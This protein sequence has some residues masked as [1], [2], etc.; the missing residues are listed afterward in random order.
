MKKL[1]ILLLCLS[2][3]SV[4]F[5]QNYLDLFKLNYGN[6]GKMDETQSDNTSPNWIESATAS[7]TLPIPL[8]EKVAI[9]SGADTEWFD[10]DIVPAT[11]TF[12]VYSLTLK[13][14]LSV[15]HTDRLSATYIVLPKIAADLQ[16]RSSDDYQWGG[17]FVYSYQKTDRLKYKLGL[18]GSTEAFGFFLSPVIGF[19]YQ[20]PNNKWEFNVS[21]PVAADANYQATDYL[22]LGADFKAIIR[23]YNLTEGNLAGRHLHRIMQQFSIYGQFGLMSNQIQIQPRFGFQFHDFAMYAD[24]DMVD[25][26]LPIANIGDDRNRLNPDMAGS[27]Y[28]EINLFYRLFL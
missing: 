9:I 23:S 19:Y 14:G 17:A 11:P 6:S 22:K 12:S 25:L 4:L 24:D 15:K 5:G 28:F 16:N 8:S 13:A 3:S 10:L 27:L 21:M 26:G 18:Y 1:F 20:S 7:L 2:S